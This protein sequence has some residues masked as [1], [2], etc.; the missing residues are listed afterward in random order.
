MRVCEI[1]GQI[2]VDLFCFALAC[3]HIR[4]NAVLFLNKPTQ[5]PFAIIGIFQEFKTNISFRNATVVTD[6]LKCQS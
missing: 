3:D 5:M 1:N 2:N 4:E 6:D